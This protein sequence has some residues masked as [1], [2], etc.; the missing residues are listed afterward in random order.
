MLMIFSLAMPAGGILKFVGF[1]DTD[2]DIVEARLLLPQGTPLL[3]TEKQVLKITQALNKLNAQLSPTQPDGQDLVRNVTVIYGQ[4]P[5]ANESGPHLARIVADLLSAEE[6]NT[7]IDEFTDA[8]RSSVGD[9][10]DVISLK[11]TEPA[12]GPAGRAIEVRLRGHDLLQLKAASV[13]LQNW[14]NTFAGVVDISDD[15]RPGKRELRIRLLESAGVLGINANLVANQVRAAFQGITIDEFPVGAETYE[16][17]LRLAAE[18]R[19]SIDNLYQLSI[20][21]PSGSQIPLPNI[22]RIEEVRGWARIN[23]VDRQRTITVFGDV[24]RDVANAQE[25]VALAAKDIFPIIQKKYPGVVIDTEGESQN[26]AKTGQSI[27]RNVILGLI[28]VYILLAFQFRGYLA[29]LTVMAIIP[30]ALIGVIFGHVALD[31]D[32]T[33]PS[34]IG[35]ASLFG[36]VVN[37][38]ILL[39]VFIRESRQKGIEVIRAAEE[40]GRNRFRPILLTSITTIAGLTPL[41]L[42]TSLQAQILIPL[43]ASLAFGLTSATITALFLVPVIYCILNDFNM[44]GE[45]KIDEKINGEALNST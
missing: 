36:V 6:R 3:E 21:G 29:P 37:D 1:P 22:A 44:L 2:G 12:I 20:T 39:V 9:L 28:G 27:I 34:I 7:T 45:V 24:Q 32:L 30:T 33:M 13:E 4:N 38:S 19:E 10:A 17:D 43:A 31:L 18:D 40:A 23:R 35:M 25:L 15:L 11:F 41:L 26:M 14:F 8:W 42:E 5:D 16:V